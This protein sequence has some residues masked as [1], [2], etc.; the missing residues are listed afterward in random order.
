MNMSIPNDFDS[1]GKGIFYPPG[2]LPVIDG[3]RVSGEHHIMNL[4]RVFMGHVKANIWCLLHFGHCILTHTTKARGSWW[5]QTHLIE[6][7]TGSILKRT[8]KTARVFYSR[9]N[10]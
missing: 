5:S 8:W 10:T 7:G 3:K 6:V 4:I 1:K 9:D 2:T